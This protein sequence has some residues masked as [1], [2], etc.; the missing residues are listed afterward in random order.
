MRVMM[1]GGGGGRKG[2]GE[3][4]HRLVN[5]YI[6]FTGLI[7]LTGLVKMNFEPVITMLK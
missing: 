5:S 4:K 7:K 1:G 6:F 3:S 2:E